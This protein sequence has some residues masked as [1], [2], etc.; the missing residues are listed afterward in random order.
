MNLDIEL[1]KWPAMAVVGKP[2]T[3]EQAEDILIRTDCNFPDFTHAG[4]NRRTAKEFNEVF[5][6]PMEDLV[7]LSEK[8]QNERW[9]EMMGRVNKAQE[10]SERYKKLRLY[11]LSNDRI[12]SAYI[13]GPRG[14]CDWSG[15]IYST[16]F[17]IGKWPSIGQVKDEWET[18]LKAFP[19]LDLKCQ[20]FNGETSEEN[21]QPVVEYV[22][23][24]G[25][26]E[27]VEPK[28]AIAHP[29]PTDLGLFIARV[30][31]AIRDYGEQ[32][33]QLEEFKEVMKRFKKRHGI[34]D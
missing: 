20:L 3:K 34:E 19:F 23:R 1:P 26:V 27:V 16:N 10:I 21:L 28:E 12:I 22:V 18:I 2:V 5:G 25:K 13:G 4:N 31:N 24:K 30:H 33:I 32:G 7:D 11:Y 9:K 6:I 15:N 14:W 8:D 29:S 17:N